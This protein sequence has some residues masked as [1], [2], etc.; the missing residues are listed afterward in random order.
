[1]SDTTCASASEFQFALSRINAATSSTAPDV[2]LCGTTRLP[3]ES[4]VVARSGCW[5]SISVGN[6]T[7]KDDVSA[8]QQQVVLNRIS[9]ILSCD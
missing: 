7:S 9:S 3:T 4:S 2:S 8:A 5:V 6:A 1:M